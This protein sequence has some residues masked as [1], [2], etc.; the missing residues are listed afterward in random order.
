MV[1]GSAAKETDSPVAVDVLS[2]KLP[3]MPF[4]FGFGQGRG[5]VER[6]IESQLGRDL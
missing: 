3:E 2:S 6:T 1:V 5:D 4:E